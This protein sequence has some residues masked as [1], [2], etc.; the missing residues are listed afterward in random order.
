MQYS[1]SGAGQQNQQV[2]SQKFSHL[3]ISLT[4][5]TMTD[6][7]AALLQ[8][9][10][11]TVEVTKGGQTFT[12]LSGNLFALGL[13]NAVGSFEGQTIGAYRSFAVALGQN[14]TLGPN[15]VANVRTVITTSAT[16]LVTTVST[17]DGNTIGTYIPNTKVFTVDV[18]QST[19]DISGGDNVTA[20]SV[21]S[22]SATLFDITGL[23]INSNS[24]Y[25]QNLTTP[26]FYSLMSQQ[27]EGAAPVYAAF[28]AYANDR[29]LD[30]VT[31]RTTN[32][33]QTGNTFIVIF[34]GYA[35]P[36]VAAQAA[37]T[38]NNDTQRLVNKLT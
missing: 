2:Q 21:V 1:I 19:Q 9:I 33:N 29:D 25:N 26:D 18:N 4:A 7:N 24:G 12:C 5:T 37:A 13:A 32:S 14:I 20:I 3:L 34:G 6:I 8:G 23:Q 15:D 10:Q 31:C 35:I 16:G 38:A 30:G 11:I 22:D 36:E 27:H 28:A 17:Y